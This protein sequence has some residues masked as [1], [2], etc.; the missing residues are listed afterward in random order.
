MMKYFLQCFLIST[1]ILQTSMAVEKRVCTV[2][3]L[4]TVYIASNVPPNTPPVVVHC[5]SKDDDLGNHTVARNQ[6]YHFDFCTNSYTTLFFCNIWWE[7][8]HIVFDAFHQTWRKPNCDYG[9]CY[10][11]V[12]SDGIYYSNFFPPRGLQKKY[13]W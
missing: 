5:K 10:W 8:K 3:S 6:D 4:I 1:F 2:T 13:D 12:K 7:N 9:T 11:L